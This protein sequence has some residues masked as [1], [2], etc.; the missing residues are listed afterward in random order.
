MRSSV[1]V[2]GLR[3]QRIRTTSGTAVRSGN[4]L[5]VLDALAPVR[6]FNR[7]PDLGPELGL[8]GQRGGEDLSD[9]LG[10]WL[11]GAGCPPG[12]FS[13]NLW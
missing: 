5:L 8:V 3:G 10:R 2:S 13:F 9:D 7:Q 12:D 1:S 4:D 11:A 6:L